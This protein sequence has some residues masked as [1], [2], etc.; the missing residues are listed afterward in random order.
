MRRE[1]VSPRKQRRRQARFLVS[2]ALAGICLVLSQQP[3]K[4]GDNKAY[5]GSA[6]TAWGTSTDIEA[7]LFSEVVN[8][9]GANVNVVTCPIVRDN[10]INTTG[11]GTAWVYVHRDA[12]A[13]SSLSCNLYSVNGSSGA[14]AFSAFASTNAVGNIRLNL[15]LNNSVAAGPYTLRCTLPLLSKIYSYIVP[16]F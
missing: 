13:N 9:S 8:T 2:A 16:E 5:P 3:A 15:Q 14:L 7:Q 10:T 1:P 12:A 6:C 4:A 11:T